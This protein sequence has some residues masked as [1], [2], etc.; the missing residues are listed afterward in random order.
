MT[1]TLAD[2]CKSPISY[3]AYNAKKELCDSGVAESRKSLVADPAIKALV[4]ELQAWPGPRISSHK[5]AQQF[6]HKLN[7]LVDVGM[8]IDDPGMRAIAD[9]ILES[10]DEHGVPC[11]TMDIPL[12]YG[13]S[14]EA[15]KAW[16]LCDAPN[17]LYALKTLGVVDER[18]DRAALWLAGQGNAFA[19]GCV[20]SKT[21]GSWRGPGKKDDPCPYATLIM[22]K[23]L[24]VYGEAFR[25]EIAACSECLLDLWAFSRTKHPYIFYMGNDFR[26]LKLPYIWY[27]ILH[28]VDTLSQVKEARTDPRFLTMIDVIRAKE[29][30]EGFVP[31]S[32]YQPWKGWDFG[33]KTQSSDW[34][35]LCVRKIERRLFEEDGA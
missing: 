30:P 6:F 24:L 18:L 3:V 22:L 12:A 33:Q 27:D 19:F 29:K 13:G 23:L 32:I 26:K 35:T 28:V 31:E 4:N 14:G 11:I 7:F 25:K 15:L 8:K 10:V 20:V 9:R 16:A 34:M 2:L 17:V 21:L 1:M 5:S